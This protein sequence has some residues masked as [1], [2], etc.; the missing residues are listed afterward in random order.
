MPSS[1]AN[2]VGSTTMPSSTNY[3]T[4]LPQFGKPSGNTGYQAP[5]LNE[6]G[7]SD[8]W[9]RIGAGDFNVQPV[10]PYSDAFI[11]NMM[12][13]ITAEGR[14]AGT[15][16]GNQLVQSQGPGAQKNA[17][18]LRM[19]GE[20]QGVRDAHGR[21]FDWSQF[22]TGV[23]AD[24]ANRR[25]SALG[26]LIEGDLGAYNARVGSER[27]RL[28]YVAQDLAER[29]S[30]Y[31]AA[32]ARRAEERAG[33]A[34][35]LDRRAADRADESALLDMELARAADQ[36]ATDAFDWEREALNQEQSD[37]Q[38]DRRTVQSLLDQ[39]DDAVRDYAFV[40]GGSSSIFRAADQAANL[41]SLRARLAALG[42]PV[43]A[44][45]AYGSRAT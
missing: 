25:L 12:S 21:A 24:N 17:A 9:D 29:E 40:G 20:S 11:Q 26:A 37:I 5:A 28:G 35:D 27:A 23:Q 16:A 4:P 33:A 43:N 34:F 39:W 15:L 19:M 10:D 36:R 7:L 45:T 31:N 18:L 1:L 22:Q 41:N 44:P 3:S 13:G 6:R 14:R 8:L 2:A 32:M 30:A 42:V 38:S